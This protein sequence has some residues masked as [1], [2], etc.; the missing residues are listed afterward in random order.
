MQ[1]YNGTGPLFPE[2]E[3]GY[4]GYKMQKAYGVPIPKEGLSMKEH[5][6]YGKEIG[7]I[8]EGILKHNTYI[9]ELINSK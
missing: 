5:P 8:I 2:T 9:N 4:H 6:L 1:Y 7:D 3:Q